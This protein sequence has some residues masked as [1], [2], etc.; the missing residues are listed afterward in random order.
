MITESFR[1]YKRVLKNFRAGGIVNKIVSRKI[2]YLEN[3]L[4]E[5]VLRFVPGEYFKYGK[6]YVKHYGRN[7]YEVNINSASIL[8]AV[9]EGRRIKKARYDSYNSI[10]DVICNRRV[11]AP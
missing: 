2:V 6:Y 10:E 9:M 4:E 3:P 11:N 5:I 1:D 7:E 8:M